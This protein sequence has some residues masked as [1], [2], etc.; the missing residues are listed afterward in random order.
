[1][2]I[3]VG[4][5]ASQLG[6]IH[7][8]TQGQQ[9]YV[10]AQV[11]PS[12]AGDREAMYA[13]AKRFAAWAPNIAVKLP[14]TAA[15]LD[16]MERI[17]QEG[18]AATITVSF[19][20][21]QVYLTAKRYQELVMKQSAG[22]KIGKCFAVIM[23]G[24][25]DDYL[26]DVFADNQAGISEQEV[27]TAGLSVVKHAYNLYQENG[28]EAVLLIAA[29]RG[30]YHVTELADGKLIMSIPPAYQKSLLT[31]AVVRERR[32]NEPVPP[33]VES[34]LKLQPEFRRAF[35]PD[36]MSEKELISFGPT[37]RTLSQFTEAGWKVL[38]QFSM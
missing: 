19:T 17:C 2:R 34:K 36:G 31:G 1:M 7:R 38:E 12:L 18:I 8:S 29:H 24:R 9:G 20:V 21:P 32:I 22:S 10:C 28:F 27:Q 30:N 4:Y 11:N 14:G 26:R 23:V 33:A 3:V 5:A 6:P 15:G 35:A 16:V 25:L 13:M 37:Q